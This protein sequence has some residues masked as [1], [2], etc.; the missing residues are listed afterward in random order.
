MVLSLGSFCRFVTL[1]GDE[2]VSPLMLVFQQTGLKVL[3]VPLNF[4]DLL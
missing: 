2:I 4:P 3:S 1:A